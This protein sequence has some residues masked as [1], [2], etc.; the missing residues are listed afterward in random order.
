MLINKFKMIAFVEFSTQ[1]H[2]KALNTI[3]YVYQ[4]FY[5]G[6]FYVNELINKIDMEFEIC[7]KSCKVK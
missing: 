1:R 7:T 5:C 6:E 3:S 4:V 2:N